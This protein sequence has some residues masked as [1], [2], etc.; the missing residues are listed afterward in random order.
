MEALRGFHPV[1]K[2]SLL[3]SCKGT[4][5]SSLSPTPA[6]LLIWCVETER[7]KLSHCRARSNSSTATERSVLPA[8]PFQSCPSSFC[9][10]TSRRSLA[11][12]PT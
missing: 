5:S 2:D 9:S 10:Q 1:D 4:G 3:Q 8:R 7:V 12:A 6:S 11:L